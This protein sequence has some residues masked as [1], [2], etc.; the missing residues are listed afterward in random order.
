MGKGTW[1]YRPPVVGC[2]P[3]LCEHPC[4][5]PASCS[6]GTRYLQSFGGDV[7]AWSELATLHLAAGR[8]S[9]SQFCLEECVMLA[10]FVPSYHVRLGEALLSGGDREQAAHHFSMAMKLCEGK[11]G[12]EG[13]P[14]AVVGLA[15]ATRA[16]D[17][18]AGAGAGTDRRRGPA[19]S[20]SS[21]VCV[22][23]CA[24]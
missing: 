15:L 8:L 1:G 7:E 17:D 10:P 16:G 24:A 18:A 13:C 21:G 23:V 3:R 11:E 22:C 9:E 4:T 12:G 5:A 19:S 2:T 6:P 14:R 20:P